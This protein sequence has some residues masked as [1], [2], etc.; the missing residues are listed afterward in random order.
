MRSVNIVL[1]KSLTDKLER[2]Y[3][4]IIEIKKEKPFGD[5]NDILSLSV[6]PARRSQVT[7]KRLCAADEF[8]E[9]ID[10]ALRN[11]GAVRIM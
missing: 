7:A 2:W 10:Y 5:V 1:T 8:K 9:I 3:G 11:G 4:N 6:K